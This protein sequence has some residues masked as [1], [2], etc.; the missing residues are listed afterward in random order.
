MLSRPYAEQ[1]KLWHAVTDW[2][3]CSFKQTYLW[4]IQISHIIWYQ[5][6]VPGTL[7]HH[8]SVIK[9]SHSRWILRSADN[10]NLAFWK[11]KLKKNRWIANLATIWFTDRRENFKVKRIEILENQ[12]VFENFHLRWYTLPGIL[13]GIPY[14]FFVPTIREQK[15]EKFARKVRPCGPD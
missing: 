6:D 13:Y 7:F 2:I 3:W 12:R 4:V 8:G 9:I 15:S 14:Q 1:S 5:F 11:S 10:L